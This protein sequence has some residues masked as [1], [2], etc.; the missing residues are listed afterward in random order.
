MCDL[1]SNRNT[2]YVV[3]SDAYARSVVMR[4]L[5]QSAQCRVLRAFHPRGKGGGNRIALRVLAALG[6]SY[7]CRSSR[8]AAARRRT[9]SRSLWQLSRRPIHNASQKVTRSSISTC[10]TAPGHKVRPGTMRLVHIAK[11][12]VL[13]RVRISSPSLHSTYSLP[14]T[15]SPPHS[16]PSRIAMR[17]LIIG[18]LHIT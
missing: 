2:Q 4:W 16:P 14:P 13:H 1:C 8:R 18:N 10:Q 11:D 5:A 12:S 15:L 6:P 7:P 3:E 9:A 17:C